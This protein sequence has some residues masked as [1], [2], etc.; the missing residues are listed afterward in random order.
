[1]IVQA[2]IDIIFSGEIIMDLSRVIQMDVKLFHDE[3][4]QE[5]FR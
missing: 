4:E 1:M 3:N 2:H 5:V